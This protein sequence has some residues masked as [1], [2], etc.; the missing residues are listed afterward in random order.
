[1][2][3]LTGSSKNAT[4]KGQ[5]RPNS[6]GQNQGFSGVSCNSR[7]RRSRNFFIFLGHDPLFANPLFSSGN[8]ES[9]QLNRETVL[10]AL[11][12]IFCLDKNRREAMTFYREAWAEALWL[13]NQ[14]KK[15]I[16]QAAA[17][18]IQ[19][20]YQVNRLDPGF[21]FYRAVFAKEPKPLIPLGERLQK[22]SSA[23]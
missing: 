17:E 3:V 23:G 9:T 12:L 2:Q 14:L 10:A 1:M 21:S 6:N 19:I 11:D 5:R 7:L 13:V 20:D 18:K 22:H 8:P 15:Q 4:V 16:P